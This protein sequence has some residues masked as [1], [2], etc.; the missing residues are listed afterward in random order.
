MSSEAQQ[1]ASRENGKKSQGPV[2]P[3]GRAKCSQNATKHSLTSKKLVVGEHERDEYDLLV[4]ST[5][6]FYKPATHLEK[7]V[8]QSIAE[9]EWR[10]HKADTWESGLLAR[11]RD[12]YGEVDSLSKIS[13]P[14][15]REVHLDGIIYTSIG[16]ALG[17]LALQIS[18]VQRTL[19]RRIKQYEVMRAEREAVEIAKRNLAMNSLLGDPK[20][21]SPPH[22][23]VGSVFSPEFLVSRIEFKKTNPTANIAFFDRAWGDPKAKVPTQNLQ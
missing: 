19:E 23:T 20:D 15:E 8:V 18:R 17:N 2:T 4:V 3:E 6:D 7:H 10:L 5:F 12:A 9:F 13:D 14:V 11:E 21:P 1:N 22:P 16:K